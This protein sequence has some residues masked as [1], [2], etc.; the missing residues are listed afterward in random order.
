MK[1]LLKVLNGVRHY[2]MCM[3]A[4]YGLGKLA[5]VIINKI[6]INEDYAEMHPIKTILG[7]IIIF[8]VIV[9]LPAY[10]LARPLLALYEKIDNKIN[11]DDE[12][13]DEKEDKEDN[14]CLNSVLFS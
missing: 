14:V 9:M 12:W 6:G 11:E 8:G 1:L 3:G 13:N 4:G 5:G 7:V 2:G 10:F